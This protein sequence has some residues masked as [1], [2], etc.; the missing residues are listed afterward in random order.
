MIG[1]DP[2][3]ILICLTGGMSLRFNPSNLSE[4][5]SILDYLNFSKEISSLIG[6]LGFEIDKVSLI[7]MQ[8]KLNFYSSLNL[9]L[10]VTNDD[11]NVNNKIRTGHSFALID[12]INY[13]EN[14]DVYIIV[15]NSLNNN[16]VFKNVD[17]E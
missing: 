1:I 6:I 11:T 3:F 17:E 13:N 7:F 15:Y 2:G 14:K 12:L 8:I 4:K 5:T 10:K 16:F 9:I